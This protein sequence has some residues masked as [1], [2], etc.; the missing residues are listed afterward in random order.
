MTCRQLADFILEYLEGQLPDETRSAFEHHLTLC[1][2]CVD[3]IGSYAA[4]VE[5]GR[6]A[7]DEDGAGLPGMPEALVQAILAARQAHRETP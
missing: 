6:R 5:L 7:F 3:Y 2:N 4:T 1:P